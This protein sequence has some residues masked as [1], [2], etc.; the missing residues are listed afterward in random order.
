MALVTIK[1]VFF[2]FGGVM[3]THMDGID[4]AAVESQLGLPERTLFDCLY[5]ESPT[6]TS[7]SAPAHARSGS[8]RSGRRP[9]SGC[10]PTPL[11]TS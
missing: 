9:P 3:L 1:A 4:H 8:T 10:R 7:R 11:T 6:A 2:D 5:R